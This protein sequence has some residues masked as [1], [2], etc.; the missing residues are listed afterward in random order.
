MVICVEAD[1]FEVVVLAAYADALLAV[2][3]TRVRRR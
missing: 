1:F 3:G 2:G